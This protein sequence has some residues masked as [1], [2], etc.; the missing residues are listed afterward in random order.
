MIITLAWR[1]LWRNKRRSLITIM[2]VVM[3]VFLS[4]S[5]NS[6]QNGS[7]DAMLDGMIGQYTG[8]IQLHR[9]GY[10]AD[11][12]INDLMPRWTRDSIAGCPDQVADL[13]PRLESFALVSSDQLTRGAMVVGYDP[14]KEQALTGLADKVK[15]GHYPTADEQALLVGQRLARL[16][17]ID[18]G[19]TLIILGQGYHGIN[20][21][22]KYPVAGIV[23]L[24]SPDLDKQVVFLPLAATQYLFGTDD[25]V[26]GH[27]VHLHHRSSF[28]AIAEDLRPLVPSDVEVMHWKEMMP[29]LVQAIQADKGGNYIMQFVIYLIIAF[30]IF[31]TLLMMTA[32]RRKEFGMLMAIGMSRPK[33]IRMV[34]LEFVFLSMIGVVAG[35]LL[36]SPLVWY[37][38]KYPIHAGQELGAVFEEYGME[39][40]YTA[41]PDP[42]V[43][44]NQA[45]LI[46]AITLVLLIYP[47]FKLFSL[48]A[49]EAMRG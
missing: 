27:V 7:W 5:M 22:G 14:E 31:S 8:Y 20:A 11:P 42:S 6:V 13:V 40:I 16:L 12:N 36:A 48:K 15:A 41:S 32:E 34:T 47:I 3:A 10:W 35:G 43:F 33:M 39:P 49:V 21:V 1:N 38:Y 17:Q 4:I 2:S 29:D 44:L 28:I 18:V 37:L 26:T 46:L 24:N 45:L 23:K 9:Q 25:L 30:G 19:D